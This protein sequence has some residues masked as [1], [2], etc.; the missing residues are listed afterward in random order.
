LGEWH[1][2]YTQKKKERFNAVTGLCRPEA[3]SGRQAEG[4][5]KPEVEWHASKTPIQLFSSQILVC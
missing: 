5:I 3:E 1:N 4:L 2:E